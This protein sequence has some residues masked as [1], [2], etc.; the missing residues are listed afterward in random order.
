MLSIEELAAYGYT[1]AQAAYVA[2]T[3]ASRD[4][5]RGGEKEFDRN[6]SPPPPPRH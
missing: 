5:D 3:T 1:P 2:S 6:K 4:R